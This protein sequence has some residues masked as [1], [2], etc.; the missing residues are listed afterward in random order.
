MVRGD[1]L[2]H[3]KID[4]HRKYAHRLQWSV[5]NPRS[6]LK[7]KKK[8]L[9]INNKIYEEDRGRREGGRESWRGSRTRCQFALSGNSG[10][11]RWRQ[12]GRVC[13]PLFGRCVLCEGERESAWLCPFKTQLSAIRSLAG[14]FCVCVKAEEKK[15][16]R[17]NSTRRHSERE[18]ERESPLNG[19]TDR[20]IKGQ[21]NQR[22]NFYGCFEKEA[23]EGEQGL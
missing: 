21:E 8:S 1:T 15:R 6:V 2:P 23:T 13:A 7:M 11:V 19:I 20:I 17:Q 22:I 18:R 4:V 5:T 3:P 10:A 12:D 9:K 16:E 14:C